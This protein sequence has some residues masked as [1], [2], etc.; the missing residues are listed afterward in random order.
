MEKTLLQHEIEAAE[1]IARQPRIMLFDAM[2]VG[3]TVSCL[4]GLIQAYKGHTE[5]VRVIVCVPNTLIGQWSQEVSEWFDQV[6]HACVVGTGDKA[7][8][9]MKYEYFTSVQTNVILLTNY[10]FLVKDDF[11]RKCSADALV[12]DEGFLLRNR[13]TRTYQFL[14][15]FVDSFDKV[16]LLSGN[17][18]SFS[19]AQFY[20]IAS[21]LFPGE[22]KKGTKE[23]MISDLGERYISRGFEVLS[24]T[25]KTTLEPEINFIVQ[26]V[27]FHQKMMLSDLAVEENRAKKTADYNARKFYN[28]MLSI[29]QSPRNFDFVYFNSPKETFMLE[30]IRETEGKTVVYCSDR[31]FYKTIKK[32]LDVEHIKYVMV[33]GEMPIQIRDR[34]L[35]IFKNDNETNVLLLSGVGKFGLNLQC[36][37]TLICM[38]V[39]KSRFELDQLIGRLNRI[40]QHE[41]VQCFIPYHAD[42]EEVQLVA[43]LR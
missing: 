6:E 16:V 25:V 41:R 1:I 19:N 23:Q 18:E 32:D 33:S 43:N 26:D 35:S 20:N 4:Q 24:E 42:S 9:E 5:P 34:S 13:N 12:L 11:F 27:T 15:S 7:Q 39:P 17:A 3:K 28:R 22:V 40:D 38:G 14:R 2:G 8:R 37:S 10:S 36:A 21:L 29:L 30:K 31:K